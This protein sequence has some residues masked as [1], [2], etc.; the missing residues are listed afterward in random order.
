MEGHFLSSEQQ[1]DFGRS[2]L[3]RIKDYL[4]EIFLSDKRKEG[5]ELEEELLSKTQSEAEYDTLQEIF[6]EI[7]L[8]YEKREEFTESH[9]DPAQWTER[10]LAQWQE[11]EIENIIKQVDHNASRDD[12]DKIK[13][14]IA[15][16][17]D[18]D[19]ERSSK[20]LE[21]ISDIAGNSKGEETGV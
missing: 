13:A 1:Q 8:T 4:R 17:I 20:V 10:E 3:L 16:E 19:I 11:I 6:D 21:T 9:K 12:V 2:L 5:K 7:D 14:V 18:A 15:S